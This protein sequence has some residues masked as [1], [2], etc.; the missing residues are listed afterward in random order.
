MKI[1]I[2]NT[3]KDSEAI[4]L[5]PTIAL[6]GSYRWSLVFIWIMWAVEIRLR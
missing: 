2:S 1:V 6:Q 4:V 3:W 5:T